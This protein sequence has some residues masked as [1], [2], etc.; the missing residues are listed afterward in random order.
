V[1]KV[2]AHDRVYTGRPPA[3]HMRNTPSRSKR[4]FIRCLG[5]LISSR[6]QESGYRMGRHIMRCITR[7]RRT[8][9]KPSLCTGQVEV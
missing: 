8:L 1:K 5:K 3:V 2:R 4:K 7:R 9:P 6:A